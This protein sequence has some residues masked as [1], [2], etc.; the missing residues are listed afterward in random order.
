MSLFAVSTTDLSSHGL[1]TGLTSS[2]AGALA[3]EGAVNVDA[4]GTIIVHI[5]LFL[6]LLFALKPL[7]FDPLMKLFEER[8]KRTM[9]TKEAARK[10]DARS[11]KAKSTY[12]AELAKARAE[13]NVEREKLRAAGLKREAEL[14]ATVRA[15][16]AKTLEE[17]RAKVSADAQ[18]AREGLERD[19]ANLAREVASRVLGREVRG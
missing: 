12:D 9:G 19:A 4:D 17:G 14:L 1:T 7:L 11:A 5:A 16:A 6:V 18:A 15:E 2:L 10:E 8:E 3:S 13:G